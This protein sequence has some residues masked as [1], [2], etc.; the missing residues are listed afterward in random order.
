MCND[1]QLVYCH[2]VYYCTNIPICHSPN[3]NR[4]CHSAH[5][6]SY[7]V[8]NN[9]FHHSLVFMICHYGAIMLCSDNEFARAFLTCLKFSFAFRLRHI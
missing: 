4:A 1:I 9:V 3:I 7:Y 6:V 8:S 2:F 5:M